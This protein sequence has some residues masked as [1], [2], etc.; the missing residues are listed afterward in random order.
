MIITRSIESILI[1]VWKDKSVAPT[2]ILITYIHG[3]DNIRYQKVLRMKGHLFRSLINI[4]SRPPSTT[5]TVCA[6]HRSLPTS[7][8]RSDRICLLETVF[9]VFNKKGTDLSLLHHNFLRPPS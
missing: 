9:T 4:S 2:K 1:E 8:G 6:R 7:S 5:R 3:F